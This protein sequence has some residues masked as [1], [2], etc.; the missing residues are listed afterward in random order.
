MATKQERFEFRKARSRAPVHGAHEGA[1]DRARLVGCADSQCRAQGQGDGEEEKRHR[2]TLREWPHGPSSRACREP[3][4]GSRYKSTE[5]AAR[6]MTE[7]PW[8][9]ANPGAHSIQ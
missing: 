5:S 6:G 9:H 8:P 4:K 1:G 7:I 3:V 2:G